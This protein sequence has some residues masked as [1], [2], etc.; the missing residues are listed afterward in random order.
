MQREERDKEGGG[1]NNRVSKWV[2]FND[3]D[4]NDPSRVPIDESDSYKKHVEAKQSTKMMS[5]LAKPHAGEN[6]TEQMRTLLIRIEDEVPDGSDAE[7]MDK[8]EDEDN[9]A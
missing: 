6:T 1:K 4:C 2:G 8:G 5:H 7:E 9:A 3:A